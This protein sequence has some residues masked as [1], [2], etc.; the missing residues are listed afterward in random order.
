MKDNHDLT[1]SIEELIGRINSI[2]LDF[3]SENQCTIQVESAIDR[4]MHFTEVELSYEL[5]PTFG[6]EIATGATTEWTGTFQD[7]LLIAL[8][9][10]VKQFAVFG[11]DTADFIQILN[12]E[13]YKK[14]AITLV[15]RVQEHGSGIQVG[16]DTGTASSFE[17][18]GLHNGEII[19]WGEV[20]EK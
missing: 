16:N 9:E 12:S 13:D 3:Y 10:E 11:I 5:D 19:P 6:H 4:I 18:F 14:L 7:F 20:T 1:A 17:A 15:E 8:N 2:D